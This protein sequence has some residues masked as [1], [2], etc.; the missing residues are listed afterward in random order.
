M[1][2]KEFWTAYEDTGLTPE[3]KTHLRECSNCLNEM[4]TEKVL[5]AT[6][7]NLPEYEAPDSLWDRIAEELPKEHP[8]HDHEI[9]TA[10]VAES[11]LGKV[12]IPFRS[13]RVQMIVAAAVIIL[14]SVVATN[15]YHTG[16][17]FPGGPARQRSADS[18]SLEEI[19]QEYLAAIDQLTISAEELKDTMDPGLYDLY[20]NKL[21][22]LDEHIEQCREAL[23]DNEY[24]PNAR[25]YLALAYID[26]METLQE[27]T[28][29]Q[30]NNISS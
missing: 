27:M 29:A 2:C 21:A 5:L 11:T 6:V 20:T 15:M 3:L 1:N 23:D 26:K 10:S 24:N 16:Q 4:E 30:N 8:V 22:I 12:L 18:R 14:T 17:I 13:L 28:T 19:E 7:R 9:E 25:H